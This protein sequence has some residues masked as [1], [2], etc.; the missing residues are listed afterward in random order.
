MG[1]SQREGAEVCIGVLAK[2]D[3]DSWNAARYCRCGAE[4][5]DRLPLL[6]MPELESSRSTQ[7]FFG[8]ATNRWKAASKRSFP[9]F[10]YKL[11]MS[12]AI[13]AHAIVAKKQ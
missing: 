11:S 13:A 10:V 7:F 2:P 5:L 6:A 9:V 8:G 1:R 12:S 4:K 3:V